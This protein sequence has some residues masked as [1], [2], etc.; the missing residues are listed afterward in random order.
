MKISARTAAALLVAV[1]PYILYATAQTSRL[2]EAVRSNDMERIRDAFKPW[3]SVDGRD[4]GGAT[5][6][7]IA[8]EQGNISA[9][10]FLIDRGASLSPPQY[11]NSRT[12]YLDIA[13]R[14]GR[15]DIV[16]LLLDR[17]AP[18]NNS[19]AICSAVK[20]LDVNIVD[21]LLKRGA[22]PNALNLQ[23]RS[24]LFCLPHGKRTD[25]RPFKILSLLIQHGADIEHRSPDGRSLF[26]RAMYSKP[27]DIEMM[28]FLV[29]NGFPLHSSRD[30]KSPLTYAA[31]AKNVEAVQVLLE[32]GAD[33]NDE[34]GK[35]NFVGCKHRT[36]PLHE[37][38]YLSSGKDS[39][40]K[41]Q[42]LEIT[43]LLMKHGAKP[44]LLNDNGHSPLFLATRSDNHA[45]AKLL[46]EAG[47]NPG[48][49]S[50]KQTGKSTR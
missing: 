13:V 46:I 33:A 3:K 10:E 19:G 27:M 18:T 16:T 29:A 14:L 31:R 43:A 47:A 17:N 7:K 44:N 38:V 25:A 4:R 20:L 1:M 8:V 5:P 6:L 39:T 40:L 26:S 35:C 30:N 48:S 28:R 41:S 45:T 49:Y 9:V 15:I 22:D 32:L 50:D 42:S 36:R 24:A 11:A 12:D 23:Q 21:L 2:H 37:A 34:G